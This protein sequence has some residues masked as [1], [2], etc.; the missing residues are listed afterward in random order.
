MFFQMDVYVNSSDINELME[1]PIKEGG[2][3]EGTIYKN[4][5]EQTQRFMINKLEIDIEKGTLYII[6]R[7]SYNRQFIWTR[8]LREAIVSHNDNWL[9][10]QFKTRC[11]IKSH[12][13]RKLSQNLCWKTIEITSC[14]TRFRNATWTKFR[15]DGMLTMKRSHLR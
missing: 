7:L 6:P 12:E 13:K 2:K 3:N 1:M 10:T 11:Y 14:R 5:N 15:F 9:V 8:F 4:L